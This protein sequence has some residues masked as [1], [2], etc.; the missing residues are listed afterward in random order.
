MKSFSFLVICAVTLLG[1]SMVRGGPI[2]AGSAVAYGYSAC[3]AGYVTCLAA[4]GLT[5][6]VVGPVGWVAWLTSAPAA[7]SAAQGV[8]MAACTAGGL[9]MVAAPT[10]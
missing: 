6:G 8:C 5:A 2:A 4:S 10:P 7:C 1:A 9:S 3:N